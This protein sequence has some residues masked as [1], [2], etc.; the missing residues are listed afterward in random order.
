MIQVNWKD[1]I[2]SMYPEK[3]A[4]NDYEVIFIEESSYF[5]N[6]SK[7]IAHSQDRCGF[8]D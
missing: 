1:Y 3:M 2:T 6:L 5:Q 7:L 4:P 8:K